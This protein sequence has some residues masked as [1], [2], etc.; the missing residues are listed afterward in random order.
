MDK[1]IV[2]D[3]QIHANHGVFEE[4]K[5]LGQRFVLTIEVSLPLG[6]AGKK[7]DLHAS[8]HYG[9][10]SHLVTDAFKE[11]SLD[12]IEAAAEKVANLILDK[13]ELAEE[14]KVMLKKPWAPI[15]LPVEYAAVEIT[16]RWHDVYIAVGSNMGDKKKH[17]ENGLAQLQQDPYT[18]LVKASK[19]YITEPWGYTDQEEFMNCVWQIKTTHDPHSLMDLLMDI[20]KREERERTLR[21][22]PRTL[23]LDIL[24]FDELITDDEK[25]ILPHPRMEERMFVLEPLAEIAPYK[26]HPLCGKRIYQLKD[27]LPNKGKV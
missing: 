25:V 14:V 27:E 15:G 2:K 20:E 22:G 4:E 21:W 3:L 26:L 10:L 13:Y 23:D 18:R 17:I 11:M 16:R 1:I 7:D 5:K 8:I 24:L 12:L 9:E 19:M 6:Q